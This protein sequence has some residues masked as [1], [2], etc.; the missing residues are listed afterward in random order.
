M[1][2]CEK[3]T[4]IK[5]ERNSE[6]NRARRFQCN[7]VYDLRDHSRGF[8]RRGKLQLKQSTLQ[9]NEEQAAAACKAYAEAQEIFHRTDWDGDGILEYTPKL[10]ELWETQS[11]TGNV[12]LLDAEFVAA[13]ATLPNPKPYKGYLFKPL[14]S[15]IVNNKTISYITQAGNQTLG[16]AFIAYPAQYKLTGVMTFT[17]SSTG[18]IYQE[19]LGP[20]TPAVVAQ[21]TTFSKASEIPWVMQPE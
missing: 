11:G 4:S 12:G 21:T 18:T 16:Y 1:L 8:G 15:R 9:S 5:Y 10:S 19:D 3:L 2:Y 13:D 7:I 20:D 17:I 14:H 6:I